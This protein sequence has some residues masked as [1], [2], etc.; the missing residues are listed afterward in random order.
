MKMILPVIFVIL[1]IILALWITVAYRRL[2]KELPAGIKVLFWSGV[3]ISVY[4]LVH[5]VVSMLT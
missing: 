5:A 2:G 3:I 4:H 1:S